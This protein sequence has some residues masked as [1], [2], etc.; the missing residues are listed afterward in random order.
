MKAMALFIFVTGHLMASVSGCLGDAGDCFEPFS[1]AQEQ[2]KDVFIQQQL[3]DH[4]G[5]IVVECNENAR[6]THLPFVGSKYYEMARIENKIEEGGD[7][8][9]VKLNGFQACNGDKNTGGQINLQYDYVLR[10]NESA[11]KGEYRR[12]NFDEMAEALI[13]RK[14]LTLKGED[15]DEDFFIADY[16]EALDLDIGSGDDNI[17]RYVVLRNGAGA[18]YVMEYSDYLV[19]L[20]EETG[21]SE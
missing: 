7:F 16:V 4:D 5:Y 19:N 20:N 15:G 10:T 21:E 11:D 9:F 18:E 1:S 12:S 13:K 8:K 17:T 14:G 6:A 2:L 3:E